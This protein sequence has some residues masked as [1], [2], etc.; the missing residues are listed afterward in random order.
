M[1]GAQARIDID[2][3]LAGIIGR[4]LERAA[5][6]GALRPMAEEIAAAGA[7]D[8]DRRFETETAPS[9]EAWPQSIRAREQGGQTLT[10]SARLRRSIAWQAGADWAAWGTNVVYA[11]IHQFGGEIV[12]KSADALYFRIGERLIK[13]SKVDAPRR[14][15]LGLSPELAASIAQDIVPHHLRG[16]VS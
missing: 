15:F 10:D 8:T 7:A 11:G 13:T 4:R 12:P 5:R 3:P 6:S 14:E 16:L 1:A 2:F 9:G